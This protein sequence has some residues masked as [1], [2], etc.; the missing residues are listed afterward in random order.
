MKKFMLTTALGTIVAFGATAQTEMTQSTQAGA[1]QGSVP[2]FLVSNFTGK[3]L[4][5]L[6]NEDS[7]A[8]RAQGGAESGDT[9]MTNAERDSLRWTSSDTFLAARDNWEDIG[10]IEDVV[11]TQ[12]GQVRGI[13]LDV[14]GFLGFGAHT[15]M[16]ETPDLYF[17][18]DDGTTEDID[19]FFV[20]I[21]MSQD[22]LE[23]LPEWDDD[24]LQDGFALTSD[25]RR[26]SGMAETED[27]ATSGMQSEAEGDVASGDMQSEQMGETSPEVF[28][29]DYAMVE[30]EDRTV[31]RL[32][33]ASVYDANGEDI[34]SVDD[35]VL[36]DGERISG[37][38]VDVG[39]VLGVGSH[40]VNLPIDQAQI[41]WSERNDDVRVQVGMTIEEL[42]AMPEHEG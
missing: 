24:H 33:G 5:T 11:M 16:V 19:D 35:V 21:A 29:G 22:E 26:E 2:A 30:G 20:V 27:T 9:S 31:D 13:I 10:A 36:G 25:D 6:D 23:A 7:R 17:V 40:T 15:V 14:G 41:G 1:S 18:S 32:L 28:G 3:S 37:L 12:D 39:G 34:G 4:Y 8:L 42:E 38:L